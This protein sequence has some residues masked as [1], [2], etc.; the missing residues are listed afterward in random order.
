MI[1]ERHDGRG[2]IGPIGGMTANRRDAQSPL[3]LVDTNGDRPDQVRI[4]VFDVADPAGHRVPTE[5]PS[6]YSAHP[7]AARHLSNTA[8]RVPPIAMASA[9]PEAGTARLR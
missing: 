6:N 2:D 8:C 5:K 1:E 9:K 3:E 7:C 4:I